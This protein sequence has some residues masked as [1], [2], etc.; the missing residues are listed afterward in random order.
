MKVPLRWLA[1][2][3]DLVLPVPHL[4]ERLTLAG[5]EVSG[6]RLV[7]LPAPEGLVLRDSAPRPVWD[8]DKVLIGEVVQVRKHPDAD[9]LL[10][11]TVEYGKGPHELVTGA[12]NLRVGDRGQ[13]VVVAL[14]GAVLL[15]GYAQPPVL[16]QLKPARIRGIL[17]DAM[18]CSARE[19]GLADEHE[20]I[21]ILEPDAP[22]GMP[23][24]DFMG[25]IVLELEVL[26][27][28]AR[29]LSLLGV[30][31]EVAA[32]TGQTLKLP[33]LASLPAASPSAPFATVAIED[34]QRCARYS[35]TLIQGVRVGPAPAWMQ[36]RLLLAGMRPINS[37]V[38]ITNYVML[39]WG[40]PLHAFDYDKLLARSGGARPTIRVRAAGEGEMLTTLDGVARRLGPDHLVIADQ[41]GPIA[42]AGVMGGA[43]TEVST[44][45]Q[46]VLLEAASF[47]FV[48]IRRTARAF[49]L[50]SEASHRFSRGIHPELVSAAAARASALLSEHC[51][52]SVAGVAESYPAP[53]PPQT[54]SLPLAEVRRCLG[55]SLP[56]AEVCRI[57]QAL[58]FQVEQQDAQTLQVT[59]PPH[60]LD[61]QHGAADLIEEL[62]RVHG[63][64]RLP[65]TLLREQLPRQRGN[66]SLELEERV[67]DILVACG[68]Q[69]VMNYALTTPQREAPLVGAEA[70]YVRL[71]NPVTQE[72]TVMR[73]SVLA[74]VLESA[75]AN[76]RH[77]SG[78]RLFEIGLVYL[79][80]PG[81]P[82]PAE[83]RRLAVVLTG[84]RVPEFWDS[85]AKPPPLDFFDLK[86]VV[87]ALLAE[88]HIGPGTFSRADAAWLHPGRSAVLTIEG[89]AVGQFGQLHP[90]LHEHFGLGRREV[91]V[92]E[93]DLERLIALVPP[94]YAIAPVPE[95]P[96]IRQDIALVLDEGIPAAQVAAEIR[97]GGG[98]L[99]HDVR[100]FDV[101]RGPNLPPGKK[102]L[103]FALTF[104]ALDRTLTDK[105]AAKVQQKIVSRLERTL[106][107]RLRA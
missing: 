47:D 92:G 41:T 72:R 4:V 66:R 100:L 14:S 39:E 15:D 68:L 17:S 67:R 98:D 61:I 6:V 65:A 107:A 11:A 42:L 33:R 10:L 81:T 91:L 38:D 16:K 49:D 74:S 25:D 58:E 35:A 90:G 27:N 5:L 29:C 34:S 78:L 51:G 7:G 32:L 12:T 37:I 97:A 40:Q 57:L 79:P 9:R 21:L 64:D 71:A 94:R 20:G 103:A 82:F 89:Q 73:R 87:E 77:V 88:L 24:A 55:I 53:V 3:V 43:E 99:L 13:K 95:F 30:A 69:E 28:M 101:Y 75:A 2:Y 22:V 19:L 80:Q 84:P 45:T 106:G 31:R 104:Q 70:E 46:A 105:E 60:R 48:S 59:T 62:A 36:R 1:E 56:V 86:G 52:G 18:V 85:P 8:R 102:S 83:L 54:V 96:P 93:F 26:P 44:A 76:L 50:P 63:Y 23:L